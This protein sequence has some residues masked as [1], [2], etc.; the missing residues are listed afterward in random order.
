L[1]QISHLGFLTAEAVNLYPERPALLQD[2]VVISHAEMDRRAGR[3][4]GWIP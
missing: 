4:A 1:T 2:D 3:V